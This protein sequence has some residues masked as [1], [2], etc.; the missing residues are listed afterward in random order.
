MHSRLASGK[1]IIMGKI[2]EDRGFTLVELVVVMAIFIVVI[3]ITSY[4]FDNILKKSG[5]QGKIAQSG[6]EGRVGLEMMRSDIGKAGYGLFWELPENSGSTIIPDYTTEVDGSPVTGLGVDATDFND[7]PTNTNEDKKIPRAIVSGSSTSTSIDYLVVKGTA[8][9]MGPSSKRWNFV[10]YISDPTGNY[11]I[12]QRRGPNG[13][14]DPATHLMPADRVITIKSTF[15]ANSDGEENRVL[16][17]DTGNDNEFFYAVPTTTSPN[18]P[19]IDSSSAF[20]PSGPSQRLVAYGVSDADLR[21]PY[22][23]VDF[24]VDKNTASK[25]ASCSSGTGVLYKAVANHLNPGG[26][27]RYPLLNCVGDMQ[28]V[29]YGENNGTL[30]Q[31]PGENMAV[32]TAKQ[33]RDQIKSV[34]VFFLI[35]EGKKDPS[36]TFPADTICVAPK[37][38]DGIT[39]DTADGRLWTKTQMAMTFGND[40]RNYRWKVVNLDVTLKNL[41]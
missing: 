15:D 41:K 11:G 19:V 39:C 3:I 2:T 6:I 18:E 23:R 26:F 20:R 24:Y 10:N 38:S 32:L 12:L 5:Q 8:L 25:P 34:Q 40:W 7:D 31:I 22:N 14:W 16:V 1:R 35:Q 28:A 36:F 9:G 27:T 37:M 21:M 4:A 33:I 29:F 13:T 30:L 17:V